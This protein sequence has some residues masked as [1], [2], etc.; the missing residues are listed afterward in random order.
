MLEMVDMDSWSQRRVSLWVFL[1]KNGGHMEKEN[2]NT[3]KKAFKNQILKII[4]Q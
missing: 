2:K 3:G 4:E 1:S